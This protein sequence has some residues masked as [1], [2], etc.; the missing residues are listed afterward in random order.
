MS[1]G[2]LLPRSGTTEFTT[3]TTDDPSLTKSTR[4]WEQFRG[5]SQGMV[6]TGMQG[7]L[8]T[9]AVRVYE[10]GPSAKALL[11]GAPFFGWLL[12]PLILFGIGLLGMLPI[13]SQL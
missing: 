6:R 13:Q 11:N 3:S 4:F 10:A 2:K 8:L 12:S 5:F 1:S 7:L 9:V